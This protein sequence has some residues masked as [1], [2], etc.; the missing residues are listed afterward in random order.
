MN[1]KTLVTVGFL[2]MLAATL[3]LSAFDSFAAD[4]EGKKGMPASQSK[5]KA[6]A[7]KRK[8]VVETPSKKAQPDSMTPGKGG[9]RKDVVEDVGSKGDVFPSTGAGTRKDVQEKINQ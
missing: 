9:E 3:A 1:R 2:P 6:S 7:P 8:D 5:Q 4:A